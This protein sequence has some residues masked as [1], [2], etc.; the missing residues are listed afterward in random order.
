MI[1]N[2]ILSIFNFVSSILNSL[3]KYD[4]VAQT[5]NMKAVQEHMQ[6]KVTY[7]ID[8]Y[9]VFISFGLIVFCS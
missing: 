6:S 5:R 4:F 9:A 2:I 1:Y 8:H 3:T 7:T